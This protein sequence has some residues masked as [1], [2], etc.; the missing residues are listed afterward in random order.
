MSV[1]K[2]DLK[3]DALEPGDHVVFCRAGS[4]KLLTLG[5]ITRVL[6]KTVEVGFQRIEFHQGRT[7][8]VQDSV[9]RDPSDVAKIDPKEVPDESE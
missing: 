5:H 4:S 8:I 2:V 9:L 6:K 3:G 1:A 7:R